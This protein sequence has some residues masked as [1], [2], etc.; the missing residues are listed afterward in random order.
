M[1]LSLAQAPTGIDYFSIL[2]HPHGSGRAHDSQIRPTGISVELER[3]GEVCIGKNRHVVVHSL[4]MSSKACWHLLSHWMAAFFLPAFSP[5]VNLCR[6]QSTCKNLGINWCSNIPWI[7]ENFRPLLHLLGVGHFLIALIL[8]S[9][10]AT[11][12]AEIKCPKKAMCYQNSSH[13]EGLS[14]S[15]AFSSF[16]K[17]SL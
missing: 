10:V 17:H 4:F 15:P 16:Q 13:L 1:G 14:L 3:S 12:W 5:E 11:L 2:C 8:P 6:G 9:S 7:P